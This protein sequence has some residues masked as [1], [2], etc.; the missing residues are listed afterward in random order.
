VNPNS[1]FI[2]FRLFFVSCFLFLVFFLSIPSCFFVA[3]VVNFFF[4]RFTFSSSFCFYF[5][6]FS[7]FVHLRLHCAS[8][9]RMFLSGEIFFFFPSPLPPVLL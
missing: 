4:L 9:T 2:L 5:L 8:G 6:F 1:S 3:L 7:F